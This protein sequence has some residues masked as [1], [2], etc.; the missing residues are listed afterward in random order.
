MDNMG[1]LNLP[2]D[3]E[4]LFDV[5]AS[6]KHC[7]SGLSMKP[8]DD[9]V[10]KKKRM[11]MRLIGRLKKAGFDADDLSRDRMIQ[12]NKENFREIA[13]EQLANITVSAPNDKTF[14]KLDLMRLVPKNFTQLLL[15][16]SDFKDEFQL[17]RHI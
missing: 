9:R 12:I 8:L 15:L 4:E 17:N 3:E 11:K 10:K 7:F 1:T 5:R 16:F 14:E 6:G 13:R 2:D